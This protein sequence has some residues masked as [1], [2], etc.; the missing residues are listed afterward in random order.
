MELEK[1]KIT[2]SLLDDFISNGNKVNNNNEESN[3]EDFD[4]LRFEVIEELLGLLDNFFSNKINLSNFKT[5]VDSIN[6]RK[7]YWGFRGVNG[8][9]FFNQLSKC[10]Q[11]KKDLT[12]YLQSLLKKPKNISEAKH[13]IMDLFTYVNSIK[14]NIL[15]KRKAPRPKSILFFLSYFWQLQDPEE[16]PIFFNSLENVFLELDLITTKENLWDY[17]E[18]FYNINFELKE[19][20]SKKIGNKSN[21]WF[22]EHVFWKYHL[23]K[24]EEEVPKEAKKEIKKINPKQE[25]YYEFLPLILSNIK[26]LSLNESTPA[27][28][29]KATSKLFT[30]LDF[31]VELL[32]Q[33]KGRT[34]DIIARG[35]GY[36]RS[37]PYV[38]LIDCKAR[39]KEDFKI[40]AGEERTIIEYIETFFSISP[41]DRSSDIYY[42]IVSSGFKDIS[43]NIIRKIKSK[44]S[45]SISFISIDA[46]VF[47]LALKLQKWDLD[48]ESIKSIFQKEG[49]ITKEFIQEETVGR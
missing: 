1:Q 18:E 40:N 29:E 37:K 47:L 41:K 7:P 38:L 30:M 34:T 32:G 19:L 20:F 39:S 6:K 49:K 42:L 13:K 36:G 15:D 48:I 2:L 12:K 24:Q 45:V 21:L 25:N 46:L 33:G 31:D 5:K 27:D 44:T 8:Q 28:F 26:K 4:N 11:N 22:V 9:M 43:E 14:D 17:Y 35:Y 23:K 16:Y 10:S 3:L